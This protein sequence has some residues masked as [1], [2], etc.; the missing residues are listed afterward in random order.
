MTTYQV[1]SAPFGSAHPYPDNSDDTWVYTHPDASVTSLTMTFANETRTESGFDFLYIIDSAGNVDGPFSG[2]GLAG[3]VVTLSGNSF[4]IRLTSDQSVNDYGFAITSVAANTDP[5]PDAPTLLSIAQNTA[6]THLT[7]DLA[8]TAVT[9]ATYDLYRSMNGGAWEH[10]GNWGSNTSANDGQIG[11][12][13]TYQYYVTATTSSGTSAASNMLSI[14]PSVSDIASIASTTKSGTHDR[15]S[16]ASGSTANMTREWDFSLPADLQAGDV[17]VLNI[18]GFDNVYQGDGASTDWGVTA[19][20]LP[21]DNN[22]G[23]VGS[24][25]TV[26]SGTVIDANTGQYADGVVHFQ[27][28]RRWQT[29]DPTSYYF[30]RYLFNS[31][32]PV[33]DRC[34]QVMIAVTTYR[35]AYQGSDSVVYAVGQQAGSGSGIVA[36]ETPAA[37]Y[38]H[39]VQ[40]FGGQGGSVGGYSVAKSVE[41]ADATLSGRVLSVVSYPSG[42]T[43]TSYATPAGNAPQ[44]T[45]TAAGGDHLGNTLIL[46]GILREPTAPLVTWRFYIA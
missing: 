12:G 3:A 38:S 19:S 29:G 44:N 21:P 16:P 35:H 32:T 39:I 10:R 42:L 36:P 4:S 9:G 24:G 8:W 20:G 7:I 26:E 33:E 18:L 31:P 2:G 28:H 37:P 15:R 45:G 13:W 5:P 46:K 22:A 34:K 6:G 11:S 40:A 30:W 14:T 41:H 17:V 27:L 25:G 1:S 23:W 43:G